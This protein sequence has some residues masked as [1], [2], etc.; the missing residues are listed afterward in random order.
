[1]RPIN[2]YFILLMRWAMY[3][4]FQKGINIYTKIGQNDKN[5]A[6]MFVSIFFP[7]QKT[8]LKIS[9]FWFLIFVEYQ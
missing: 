8:N 2:F 3:S 4:G 1:M 7:H 9:S 6:G 5:D